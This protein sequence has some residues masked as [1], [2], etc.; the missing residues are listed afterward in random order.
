MLLLS[1][2]SAGGLIEPEVSINTN[3]I[4]AKS[5]SKS[6]T[7]DRYNFGASKIILGD[8]YHKAI[9]FGSRKE[10]KINKSFS[11]NIIGNSSYYRHLGDINEMSFIGLEFGY[12]IP[13]TFDKLSVGVA[14]GLGSNWN[15]NF[16]QVTVQWMFE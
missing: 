1:L 2:S 10:Y 11:I 4:E 7:S 12:A 9:Y 8:T 14:A 3:K 16:N 15:Y 6:I 5:D 13:Y